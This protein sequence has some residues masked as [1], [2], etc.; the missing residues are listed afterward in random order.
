MSSYL[1]SRSSANYRRTIARATNVQPIAPGARLQDPGLA[2]AP[3]VRPLFQFLAF[4]LILILGSLQFLLP[5]THFRNPSD[6][7]RNWVPFKTS[8]SPLTKIE[9]SRNGDSGGDNGMVHVVSW[10]DCLDLRLLAV[11]ANSTLSSSRYPDLVHFHFFIPGGNEDKVSFYKL[12]VLF[13]HSNLQI[14]GQDEVKELHATA[15]RGVQYN[16]TSLEEIVP[17]LIPIVHHFL[18]KFIFVSANV[19]MKG[20]VEDLIGVDLTNYAVAAAED[21]NEKLSTYVNSDVLDAI[22]RSASKPWVPERPY[23]KDSCIPD[24]R[25]LLFD[26]NKLEKDYMEAILWW[27]KVLNLRERF[28]ILH[29][30]FHISLFSFAD[31]V[32]SFFSFC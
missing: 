3:N 19:I 8:S 1:P 23:V 30:A 18:N 15:V 4:G 14:H 25:V 9:A 10:M 29:F 26:A 28:C 13:P 24:L 5:V 22:Q 20:K 12:K 11:L 32:V 27:S 7:F 21:C 2:P 31:L 16:E 6:P 17:F